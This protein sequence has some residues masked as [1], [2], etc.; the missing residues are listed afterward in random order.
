MKKIY[1][2][3]DMCRDNREIRSELEKNA[4]KFDGDL[5]GFKID[6]NQK[7]VY[8]FKFSNEKNYLKFKQINEVKDYN[9][10]EV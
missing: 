7:V 3:T 9:I 8:M 10:L 6:D 5:Y 2:V 1:V 4:M